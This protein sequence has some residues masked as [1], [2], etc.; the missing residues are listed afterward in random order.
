MS[1]ED[2]QLDTTN[3]YHADAFLVMRGNTRFERMCRVLG[4]TRLSY[5]GNVIVL[6]SRGVELGRGASVRQA[7]E[8]AWNKLNE[9]PRG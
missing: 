4:V 9:P 2:R 8:D 1:R 5:D 7:Y 3:I 6:S